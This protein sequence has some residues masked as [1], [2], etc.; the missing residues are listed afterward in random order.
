MARHKSSRNHEG[1]IL[2][3]SNGTFQGC[4]TI[5]GKGIRRV[6]KAED[7]SAIRNATQAKKAW[8]ALRATL[9]AEQCKARTV[10]QTSFEEGLSRYFEAESLKRTLTAKLKND[11]TTDWASLADFAQARGVTYMEAFTSSL[12]KEYLAQRSSKLTGGTLVMLKTH[13]KRIWAATSADTPF[14]AELKPEVASFR[15]D[16]LSDAEVE[17]LYKAAAKYDEKRNEGWELLFRLAAQTGL[18]LAD[19]I[20]FDVQ[21]SLADDFA[22]VRPLKIANRIKNNRDAK[23]SPLVKVPLFGTVLEALKRKQQ[24]G[25]TLL[26]PKLCVRKNINYGVGKIFHLAGISTEV[27]ERGGMRL[28]TS[29]HSLRVYCVS[30]YGNAGMSISQ[31]AS[32]FG[33][34]TVQ[35][36]FHYFKAD[37]DV[38]RGMGAKIFG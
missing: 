2:K 14:T 11:Y 34:R 1:F 33:W 36:L 20:H 3:L 24:E 31:A 19:C 18:R 10:G 12:A 13:L 15:H 22:L 5:N 9:V 32:L 29:F 27:Y 8:A 7:G 4:V 23:E 17:A 28:K 30:K 25:V 35:M 16:N 37:Y 26:F 21:D 6:L 38:I